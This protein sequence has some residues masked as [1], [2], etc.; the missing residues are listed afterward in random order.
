MNGIKMLSA[1]AKMK[2]K[3]EIEETK[4]IFY[5][6]KEEN[7]I[8]KDEEFHKIIKKT[9]YKIYSPDKKNNNNLIKEIEI[10]NEL[11]NLW[12]SLGVTLEF[13][14]KFNFKLNYFSNEY[15]K[16]I[17]ECEKYKMKKIYDLIIKI[18]NE[19]IDKDK[20]ILN[21]KRLNIVLQNERNYN[22]EDD[23]N[24]I[25]AK[26][27]L[28]NLKNHLINIFQQINDLRSLISYDYINNKYDLSKMLNSYI[29]D[30]QFLLKINNDLKIIKDNYIGIIFGIKSSF[31]PLLMNFIDKKD[32]KKN[33]DAYYTLFNELIFNNYNP[34]KKIGKKVIIKRT[35]INAKKNLQNNILNKI[36]SFSRDDND[37]IKS[38]TKNDFNGNILN[39]FEDNKIE[40]VKNDIFEIEKEYKN[41]YLN[42]PIEQKVI[43]NIKDN[44]NDYINKINPM[45]IIKKQNDNLNL[46]CSLCNSQLL[47]M[48]I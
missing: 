4:K 19:L 21:L 7:N 18:T 11:I 13:R 36:Y 30:S 16:I 47:I 12:D 32:N 24:L 35:N 2:E 40:F 45:F 48:K 29:L 42:I 34:E 46:F 31:D 26:N 1:M 33:Y 8:K 9:R 10:D 28:N 44:L 17:F 20:D 25:E 41:Y 3:K 39:T 14:K 23:R 6:Q 22:I 27:T 37:D 43:F 38:I 15:Q 5:I